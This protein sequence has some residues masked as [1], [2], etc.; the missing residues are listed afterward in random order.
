MRLK[1]LRAEKTFWFNSMGNCVVRK[2][3]VLLLAAAAAKYK[4]RQSGRELFF[5]IVEADFH[6]LAIEGTLLPADESQQT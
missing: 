6:E 5:P 2:V 1:F 3:T 4:T